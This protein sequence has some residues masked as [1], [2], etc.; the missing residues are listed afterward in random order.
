MRA[1]THIYS[2]I[3]G[4]DRL[5]DRVVDLLVDAGARVVFGMPAESVNPFVD[6]LRRDGRLQ[7]IGVRHEGAAGI[8]AATYGRLTRRPGVCLGTAGPGATHL[9]LGA[10]EAAADRAPMLALT[11]QVPVSHL[12]LV[13]FQEID[14]VALFAPT[15]LLSGHLTA[16][17]QL[18]QLDRMLSEAVV[19]S[20]PVHLAIS[21]DTF[22]AATPR[23]ARRG[24]N[25]PPEPGHRVDK[26]ELEAASA[27]LADARTAIVVG[28]LPDAAGLTDEVA[29]LAPAL[30]API[31][32]LPE[33]Y[34]FFSQGS[35][36]ESAV[37]VLGSVAEQAAAVVSRAD[38][39]LL[40][41]PR[42]AA[43]DRLV[44]DRPVVQVGDG[45]RDAAEAHRA[46]WLRHL[47]SGP[48][49]L[50]YLAQALPTRQDGWLAPDELPA[51]VGPDAQL[52]RVLDQVLPEDAVLALEPGRVLD[53][54]FAGL[55][56]PGRTLTSSFGLA[57][58]GCAVP[59]AIGA[60]FAC[61]DRPVIAVSTDVGLLDFL[62]ELLTVRR[63][64][65]PVTILCL[66]T[67]A[68]PDLAEVGAAA[69]LAATAVAGPAELASAMADALAE[70]GPALL[71]LAGHGAQLPSPGERAPVDTD[72]TLAGRLADALAAAGVRHVF[73]R[74]VP[75][76]L[77]AALQR[78]GM[79]V[80]PVRHPESA[81]MTASAVAKHTGAPTVAVAAS[82]ADLILQLNGAYD[83]AVDRAPLVLI[84]VRD[85]D[86][87]LSG[88][89]LFRDAARTALVVPT[90]AA[91]DQAAGHIELATQTR[92]VTYLEVDRDD[93]AR[94]VP[95]GTGVRVAPPGD[96]SPP[97]H[98]LDAAAQLLARASRPVILVGGGGREAG[99]EVAELARLLHAPVLTTLAARGLLPDDD[100]HNGGGVGTSGHAS[101]LRALARCDVLLVL[102]T[103]PRGAA[104]DLVG[105][106]AVIQVDQDLTRL[107]NMA[108]PG[109]LL[110]GSAAVT[111]EALSQRVALAPAA[112]D[113]VLRARV[114]FLRACRRTLDG[115]RA[116]HRPRRVPG[117]RTSRL[118]PAAVATALASFGDKPLV[119][120]DVGTVTLWVYRHTWGVHDF[121]WSGSFATMGFAVPAAIGLADVAPGRP[122]VAAVGDGGLAITMSEL[123]TL[124]DTGLPV[125]VVVFNNGRLG[126]I[127]YEQEI[128]GWPE[129]AAGLHNG[130]L[131][132]T[133]EAFGIPATRVGTEEELSAALAAARS[134]SGPML[135]DA[136]VDPLELPQPAR[137][138]PRPTHLVSYAVA[139]LREGRRALRGTTAEDG[140]LYR[141]IALS[142]APAP[143]RSGTDSRSRQG[144]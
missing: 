1:N 120:V 9:V 93:L 106:F 24:R 31:L 122:V 7:L 91:L 33:G 142:A 99:P 2:E 3:V 21:S 53:G 100:P 104:F 6:A 84:G 94:P 20:G 77:S 27:L 47:G 72:G 98:L 79:Q 39:V 58:A 26:R 138:R 13:S 19:R 68:G 69:G 37:R 144:W 140:P 55:T 62:P 17:S 48:A 89:E 107:A 12:G 51:P 81:T 28:D 29:S 70:S 66:A 125:T 42:S 11:G 15:T 59:A 102:G 129:Y 30:G 46:G 10:A 88:V 117:R 83:A 56:G 8:M 95:A 64:G 135:I 139:L 112:D 134:H 85:R 130:D 67:G 123:A 5:A 111:V 116:R 137:F 60:V 45:G 121:V 108:S 16:T 22:A 131:A 63:Y 40:V 141:S 110:H 90:V 44:G 109:L 118:S 43:V 18:A 97:E 115:S 119:T 76:A 75:E 61:P 103:S 113:A 74:G 4:R 143:D 128:M 78:A 14:A 38:A 105:D 127:K 71:V 32:V 96:L 126:A 124:A 132:R 73:G 101:A 92:T 57:V 50:R 52:W 36:P 82:A 133:A 136:I 35:A 34:R 86:W 65:L 87:A 41:G 54:A 49:E 114:A 80:R 23:G 25:A